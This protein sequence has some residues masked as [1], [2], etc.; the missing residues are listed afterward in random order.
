M[1]FSEIG[2]AQVTVVT[3]GL[4][5]HPGSRLVREALMNQN[6]NVVIVDES[7]YIK[8]RKASGTK[9][10]VPLI[11]KA[12]RKVLLTGTPALARPEE[13]KIHVYNM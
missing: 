12:K 4:L 2:T 6:F 3:Y 7:H 11:R 1:Y 13:V 8:N 9:Y 10:I 5:R